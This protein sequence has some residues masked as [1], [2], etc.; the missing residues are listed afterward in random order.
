MEGSPPGS[1]AHGLSHRAPNIFSTRSKSFL[2]RLSPLRDGIIFSNNHVIISNNH[3][4][5]YLVSGFK[6]NH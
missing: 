6:T 4:V 5:L 1:S 2:K 3:Y